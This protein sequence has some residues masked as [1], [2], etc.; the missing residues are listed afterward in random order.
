MMKRHLLRFLLKSSLKIDL[1]SSK[2][3]QVGYPMLLV[4]SKLALLKK[5]MMRKK[6]LLH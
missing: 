5:V 3:F 2:E 4:L 1:K 6:K